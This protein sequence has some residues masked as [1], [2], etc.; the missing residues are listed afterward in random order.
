[1]R[2]PSSCLNTVNH[3][4]HPLNPGAFVLEQSLW[5]A[6]GVSTK[7]IV[8]TGVGQEGPAMS[9]SWPASSVAT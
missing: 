7:I 2:S 8:R 9:W 6:L 1:M 3:L 4:L 5:E